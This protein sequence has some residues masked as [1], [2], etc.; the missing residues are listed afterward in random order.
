MEA[1]AIGSAEVTQDAH[2]KVGRNLGPPAMGKNQSKLTPEQLSDL[3]RNTYCTSVTDKVD[4]KE[5][6]QWWVNANEVQG[7]SERLSFRCAG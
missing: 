5:L 2:A 4:R 7:L 3:Q 1:N 6:Q